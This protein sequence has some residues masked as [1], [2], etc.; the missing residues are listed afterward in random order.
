MSYGK[1]WEKFPINQNEIWV[2]KKNK[3]KLSV[4][5]ITKNIPEYMSDIE[6]LYCDPPWSL[7]NV[8]MFNTKAGREKM[9]G[10]SQFYKHLFKHIESINP[11]VTYLEIGKKNLQIYINELYKLYENV[12]YWEI[13]YYKTN[14]C[15]LIRGSDKKTNYDYTMLDDADTPFAAIKNENLNTIGDFC[16]GRGI[17]AIATH[18]LDKVFYG[19]EMNKRKLAVCIERCSK[20][21]VVYENY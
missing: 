11:I 10:F 3:S 6:M 5:D 14:P 13:T 4:C 15:Y 2:Y 18:K 21:G 17:T 7:G 12:Q 9:T 1:S 20:I 19:T 16:T 8:N